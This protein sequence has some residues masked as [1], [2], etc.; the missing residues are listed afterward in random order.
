MA[1]KAVASLKYKVY[2]NK[3]FPIVI[4]I[5]IVVIMDSSCNIKSIIIPINPFLRQQILDFFF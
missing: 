3:F 1:F 2:R 5:S 4:A